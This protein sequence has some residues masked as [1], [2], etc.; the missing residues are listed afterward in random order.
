VTRESEVFGLK[1]V[2]P[3]A[4]YS[5]YLF[6]YPSMPRDDCSVTVDS[7]QPNLRWQPLP[8]TTTEATAPDPSSVTY[9]L[10]IWEVS[11]DAPGDLI[12]RREALRD[13]SHALEEP[14]RPA[15]TY[16]WSIRARFLVDGQPRVADWGQRLVA[17]GEME[18][19]QPGMISPPRRWASHQ[20]YRYY[21]FRTPD[22]DS[23]PDR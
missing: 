20:Y 13:P 14:L 7:L 21:C 5:A 6:F 17:R 12:Y 3:P 2:D 19:P 1:P 23:P 8:S 22:A 9:E 11:H 10:K 18:D 16:F 15:T 4:E